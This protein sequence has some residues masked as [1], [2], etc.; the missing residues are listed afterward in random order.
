MP[1][2]SGQDLQDQLNQRQ[3]R[4]PII[5]VSGLVNVSIATRAMRLGATDVLEK[6]VFPERLFSAVKQSFELAIANKQTDQLK[7]EVKLAINNLTPKERKVMQCL[8]D[9]RTMK[10]MAELCECSI[11]T[12][13][14]YQTKVLVKMDSLNSAQLAIKMHRAATTLS[15]A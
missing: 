8:L 14:R 7:R 2:M 9:G 3:I 4:L 13:A 11:A 12:V 10:E 1:G 5:F 6:P 15:C